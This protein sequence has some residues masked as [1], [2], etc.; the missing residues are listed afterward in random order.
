MIK[1]HAVPDAATPSARPACRVYRVDSCNAVCMV[2][3][4]ACLWATPYGNYCEHPVVDRIA[5]YDPKN[6]AE[7]GRSFLH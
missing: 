5:E 6:V 1:I 7:G 3:D 2:H 4:P